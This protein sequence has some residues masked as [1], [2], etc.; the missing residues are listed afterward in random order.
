MD[1]QP[2]KSKRTIHRSPGYPAL[3]LGQAIQKAELVYKAEKKTATTPDVIASHIGFSQANGPGGRAVSALRQF[4]LIEESNGKYR[5]SDLGYTLIH[6][7]RNGQEWKAA[8]SEASKRP[9]IF[10]ELAEKYPEGLPSDATLRSE[11]LDRGFN[12]NVIPEVISIIR[13]TLSLVDA[14][15]TVY[16]GTSGANMQSASV[17]EPRP[18]T[19]NEAQARTGVAIAPTGSVK[20]Y[21]FP[22]SANSTAE[23]KIIGDVSPGDLEA[24]RDYVEFTIKAFARSASAPK[25]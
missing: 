6:Y 7:D 5:I 10:K 2:E 25:E 19:W 9:T 11:L 23:L 13:N 15:E 3:D 14:S 8:A 18:R 12:P 16:N 4:G 17:E 20:T 21:S 24:L 22:L 1:I